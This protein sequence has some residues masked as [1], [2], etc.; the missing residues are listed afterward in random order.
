MQHY[1]LDPYQTPNNFIKNYTCK[2][3]LKKIL[4]WHINCIN[5]CVYKLFFIL[6][7]KK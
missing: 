1:F 3:K 4:N 6:R 5:R 7:R 2:E